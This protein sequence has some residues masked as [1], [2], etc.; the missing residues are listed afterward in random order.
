MKEED[1]YPAEHLFV[2][3]LKDS[4]DPNETPYT[5]TTT[6]YPLYKGSYGVSMSN[7][8]QPPPGFY[9]NCGDQFIHYPI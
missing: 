4:D 5:A 3:T 7:M 9:H 8:G 2:R 6:A 1:L